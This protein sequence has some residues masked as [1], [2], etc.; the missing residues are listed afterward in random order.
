[1]SAINK[2][3]IAHVK[4]SS[5]RERGSY[6]WVE[7]LNSNFLMCAHHEF[8]FGSVSLR[9]VRLVEIIS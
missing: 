6:R 5:Q 2:C 4:A 1:M 8:I 9:R 3:K 7:K